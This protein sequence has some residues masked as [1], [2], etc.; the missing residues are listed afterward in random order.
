M[1]KIFIVLTVIVCYT[2]SVNET[3]SVLSY[4][5]KTVQNLVSSTAICEDTVDPTIDANW[6]PL[7]SIST[8]LNYIKSICCQL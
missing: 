8:K 1:T 7:T 2:I 3:Y 6:I 5:A 4:D